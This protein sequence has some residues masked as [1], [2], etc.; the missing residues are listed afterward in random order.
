MLQTMIQL[1]DQHIADHAA[2]SD[3]ILRSEHSL[4]EDE[5]TREVKLII[6]PVGAEQPVASVF[7]FEIEAGRTYEVE[8]ELEYAEASLTDEMLSRW[9]RAKEI[10]AE[11]SLQEKKR[12]LAPGQLAESSIVLDYH[13]MLDID[14]GEEAGRE[15]EI[16]I[17]QAASDLSRLLLL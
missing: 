8:I 1:W 13:F 3:V 6:A 9:E 5:E 11:I 17:K 4:L 12:F 2:V 16:I 15:A 10:V 7:L 14:G